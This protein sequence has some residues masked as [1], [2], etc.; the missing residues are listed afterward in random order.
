MYMY[1]DMAHFIWLNVN[2]EREGGEG[3]EKGEKRERRERQRER[4]RVCVRESMIELNRQ[5]DELF[6][7][8]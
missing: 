7:P 5:G 3:R 8:A 4:E 6:F 1:T 2:I